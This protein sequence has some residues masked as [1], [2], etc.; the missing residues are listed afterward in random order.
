MSPAGAF[1]GLGVVASPPGRRSALDPVTR[2]WSDVAA[3]P[4]VLLQEEGLGLFVAVEGKGLG[5][6]VA[7]SGAGS[8]EVASSG[9]VH[10]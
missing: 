3:P 1:L 8:R 4:P 5:L 6:P 2:T 9:R 10:P 7:Q